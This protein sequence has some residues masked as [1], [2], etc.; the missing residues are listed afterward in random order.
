MRWIK[1]FI[2]IFFI[3]V[4]SKQQFYNSSLKYTNPNLNEIKRVQTFLQRYHSP[5]AGNAK[6]FVDASVRYKINYKVLPSISGVEST[7]GKNIAPGSYNAWGYMCG[8]HVCYFDSF[9]EGIYKVAQTL[10]TSRTYLRFQQTESINELSCPYN[11]CSQDW[12]GKVLW[13]SKLI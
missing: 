11:N 1:I 13:F 3:Y 6:D 4:G 5:M 9:K 2:I 8:S 12:A 10:G 7:F